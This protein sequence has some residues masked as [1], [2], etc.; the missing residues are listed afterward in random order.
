MT[1][2][3]FLQSINAYYNLTILGWSKAFKL[4]ISLLTDIIL[5]G[6]VSLKIS[7]NFIATLFP[8]YLFTAE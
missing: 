6:P 4:N 8:C 5:L 3:I 1:K 2:L 7:Y